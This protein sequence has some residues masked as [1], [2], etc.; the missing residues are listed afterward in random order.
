MLSSLRRVFLNQYATAAS[1]RALSTAEKRTLSEVELT[2]EE[3]SQE[4]EQVQSY[5]NAFGQEDKETG[6]KSAVS[7]VPAWVGGREVRTGLVEP[8]FSPSAL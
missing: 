1:S 3:E 5:L 4:A 2:F 8:H 6:A 7:E